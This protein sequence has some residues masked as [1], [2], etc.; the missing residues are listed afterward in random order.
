MFE[1]CIKIWK[2]VLN[3]VELWLLKIS[4]MSIIYLLYFNTI[5]WLYVI[6]KKLMLTS[7]TF[8]KKKLSFNDQKKGFNH[9]YLSLL[10]QMKPILL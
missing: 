8:I 4:K 2:V 5:F 6:K 10:M 9:G 3:L 1:S 7:I